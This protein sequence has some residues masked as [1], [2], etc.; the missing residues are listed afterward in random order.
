MP[1]RSHG[2]CDFYSVPRDKCKF[3]DGYLNIKNKD[4]HVELC[5][6][7]LLSLKNTETLY[8]SQCGT[9]MLRYGFTSYQKRIYDFKGNLKEAF[10]SQRLVCPNCKCPGKN[11]NKHNHVHI[12]LP[13]DTVPRDDI[14]ADHLEDLV[15]LQEA[16]ESGLCNMFP[17][18]KRLNSKIMDAIRKRSQFLRGLNQKYKDYYPLISYD[19]VILKQ[20]RNLIKA[21]RK[22]IELAPCIE[23]SYYLASMNIKGNN[24]RGSA[25]TEKALDNLPVLPKVLEKIC[26]KFV[27]NISTFHLRT[28]TSMTIIMNLKKESQ[29]P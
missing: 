6:V 20:K 14:Y 8:C 1:P 18:R 23:R 9:P 22:L 21:A 28:L 3:V 10:V 25:Q 5:P 4:G 17:D 15:R 2:R 16:Y 12:I 24:Y 13:S 7:K 26:S 29:P 11:K 27:Q 19:V